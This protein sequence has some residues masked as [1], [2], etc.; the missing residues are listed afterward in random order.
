M[1][2]TV[3]RHRVAHGHVRDESRALYDSEGLLRAYTSSCWSEEVDWHVRMI[4][5]PIFL[6][7]ICAL[8][9]YAFPLEDLAGRMETVALLLTNVATRFYDLRLHA[10]GTL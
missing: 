10:Q 3:E 5:W 7:N 6:I 1:P 4:M 8:S 2:G 9:V